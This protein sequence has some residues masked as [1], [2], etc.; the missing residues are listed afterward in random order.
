M[1]ST[2]AGRQQL[3]EELVNETI[4]K[5]FGEDKIYDVGDFKEKLAKEVLPSGFETVVSCLL[6]IFIDCTCVSKVKCS[7]KSEND[8]K[9]SLFSNE[10]RVPKS[11]YSH[12]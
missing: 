10:E 8:L 5:F 9:F 7:L 1:A 4:E 11:K 3:E 2:S 12:I 6:F